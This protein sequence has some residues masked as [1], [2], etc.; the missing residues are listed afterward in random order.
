MVAHLSRPPLAGLNC[1]EVSGFSRLFGPP[2]PPPGEVR[3][4]TLCDFRASLGLCTIKVGAYPIYVDVAM[5]IGRNEL[6]CSLLAAC[7]LLLLLLLLAAKIFSPPS[8]LKGCCKTNLVNQLGDP[9]PNQDFILGP[10][11]L[12][13]S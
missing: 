2:T 8:D 3:A 10:S 11:W 1:S 4:E 6:S 7:C 13:L 5:R 9:N 12:L